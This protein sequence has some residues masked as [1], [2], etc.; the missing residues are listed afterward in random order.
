MKKRQSY[1]GFAVLLWI[2]FSASTGVEAQSSTEGFISIDCGTAGNHSYVDGITGIP[3]ASDDR[4]TDAGINYNISDI[5]SS[6]SLANR[7]LLT[8]RS[9]PDGAR[10]CYTLKPLVRGQKYLVR[11]AFLYGNY[12]G[13]DNA[14]TGRPL[15]FD[16]HL[17]VDLWLRVN[18]SGPTN[19]TMAE[20]LFVAAAEFAWVCLVNTGGGVPFISSL[21]LRPLKA[22]LYSNVTAEQ[23]LVLYWR[24]NL[25]G[26]TL[27]RYPDDAYDRLWEP[28]QAPFWGTISTTLPI[29]STD[30]YQFEAPSVVLQTAA[31]TADTDTPLSFY[32]RDDTALLEFYFALYSTEVE[33]LPPNATR[34]FDVYLNSQ[35][36]LGGYEP[37][38]LQSDYMYNS[39][40]RTGSSKYEFVLNATLNSTLPPILNALEVYYAMNLRVNATD[41]N[42]VEA[43]M[44]IKAEYRVKKN[45]QGDPCA[46]KE[47]A[48]V[49]LN[50]SNSPLRVV[51]INMSSSGLTGSISDS[52][53][54]LDTSEYLDL[55]YNN[56]TGE[57]PDFLGNLTSLK[58]LNL[59]GN[60]FTGS[61][62]S[63]LLKRSEEGSLILRF[64]NHTIPGNT[65]SKK[66]TNTLVIVVICCAVLGLL[67]ILILA[68]W[69]IWLRKRGKVLVTS[70][71]TRHTEAT[72]AQ[73][74]EHGP[75]P[76]VDS[77][78]FTFNHLQVITNNFA[79]VIGKGA[80]GTFYLG[81]LDNVTQVAVKVQ[82]QSTSQQ[83]REFEF[84]A[85]QLL[86]IHHRNLVSL[87]G[88]CRDETFLALVYEYMPQGSLKDHLQ[89]RDSLS[90]TLSWRERLIIALEA[91]Q[92]LDYLHRGCLPPIMHRDLKTS[93]ILLGEK[94]E[95]KLTDY[96]M[97]KSFSNNT[98]VT[99]LEMVGTP[100]YID[101]EFHTTYQLTE[102]SDIYSFGVVLLELITG[103]RAIQS[104]RSKVHIVQYMASYI[105]AGN[106]DAVVDKR[107]RRS[108]SSNSIRN[109]TDLAMQC[110]ADT[111]ADRPTIVDVVNQLKVCIELEATS[112]NGT[113][114]NVEGER[115]V[116][117]SAL[118]VEGSNHHL[119]PR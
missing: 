25:G 104:G 21:E 109:V 113:D 119:G 93:N 115:S 32:F 33:L 52:F 91:A 98:D 105:A 61:I 95:A 87:L 60:N 24:L 71:V 103:Q 77:G 48:W 82:S 23:P 97:S 1:F 49:G 64:T 8:L 67:S 117:F 12:D 34:V 65:R 88:Y 84:E 85:R 40:P 18:V 35:L 13:E 53:A 45:W 54:L 112:E 100:G 30:G 56:L 14:S 81:H 96:G 69:F 5:Y 116:Q 4:F 80:F 92:G 70:S 72:I 111:S 39:D 41:A 118:E 6:P 16:L 59:T 2:I 29:V 17:G 79:Q 99:R 107:F 73:K 51:S 31:T 62:P 74:N 38:Y 63:S 68:G 46:P 89:G 86:R 44:A 37:P 110:T 27:V 57:V 47:Y 50:C 9:F 36:A 106:I 43:M 90:R 55:S 26:T 78:K 28:F 19:L 66:K 11:A 20:A 101:P 22:W 76:Q 42:D 108:F 102:K 15:Q 10:N 7:Q 75:H 3:Y 114:R 83:T 94:L 58:V